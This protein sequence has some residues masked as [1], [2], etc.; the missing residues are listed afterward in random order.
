MNKDS[1]GFTNGTLIKKPE[2]TRIIWPKDEKNLI[3]E[4]VSKKPQT[5]KDLIPF[6]EKKMKQ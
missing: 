2:Y 6:F 1:V 4:M 5:K 3:F